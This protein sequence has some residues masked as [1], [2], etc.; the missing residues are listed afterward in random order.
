MAVSFRSPRRPAR[1]VQI[2]SDPDAPEAT[3]EQ[4]AKAKILCRSPSRVA[5]SIRKYLGGRKSNN[6][7]VAVVPF[8]CRNR[9]L[10]SSIFAIMA[11]YELAPACLL[12]VC[13]VLTFL[14]NG[15]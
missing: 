11:I 6:P 12:V 8:F 14:G 4:L 13:T 10:G 5:A 1:L 15:R 9:S 3:D 7:K 2:V